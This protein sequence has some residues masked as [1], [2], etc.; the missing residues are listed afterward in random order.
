MAFS[1]IN[2][3]LLLFGAILFVQSA[4]VT[5]WTA[6]FE[7]KQNITVHMHETTEINITINGLDAVELIR[8][9]PNASLRI[10]SDSEILQ[11]S[12]SNL[13]DDIIDGTYMG[14]FNITGIF[15]GSAKIGVAIFKEDENIEVS[16]QTLAVVIIRE[17]RLID[18]LFTISVAAL[19]S[20]LYINFGAALDL[21]KVKEILVRP[22]GPLIA[23]VCQFLFMPLVGYSR[24]YLRRNWIK[25]CKFLYNR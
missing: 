18:K 11:V 23:F 14:E 3:T 24:F 22:I 19:V 8:V 15:L 1:M 16:N 12:K 25:T 4:L 10:I 21:S 17:E 7:P 13:I 5:A 9:H 20:I 2:S 6:H